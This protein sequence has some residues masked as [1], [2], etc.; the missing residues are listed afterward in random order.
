MRKAIGLIQAIMIIL[1]L[2]GMMVLVIKYASI[3]ARHVADT[4]VKEQNELFLSS[5]IEQAL[6]AISEH[7]RSANGC[8]DS[9]SPTNITNNRDITYSSKVNVI[10]YYLEDGSD[11]LA[12]CPILGIP[13][14]TET[15]SHGMALFEIEVN[16]T[17]ADGTVVSRI[18]R[19]TLQQ[20]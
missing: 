15:D 8:L 16:A 4:Y 5:T 11:D 20:P 1:L 13:I 3:S 2:S 7:N 14:D 10:R 9:Y 19:R 6:L 12:D 17:R 18:L